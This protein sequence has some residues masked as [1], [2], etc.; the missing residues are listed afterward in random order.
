MS[1][2][3]QRM[4]RDDLL[5]SNDPSAGVIPRAVRYVEREDE[6]GT[7]AVCGVLW[8]V[9]WCVLCV[10]LTYTT[11][12]SLSF[13]LRYLFHAAAQAAQ[14]AAEGV[15]GAVKYTVK[16]SY[17]EIYNE[18]V[19]DLLNLQSQCLQVRWNLTNGFFVKDLI[20]VECSNA[21]DLL[22]TFALAK[23]SH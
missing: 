10:L 3:E 21:E 13:F 7:H 2:V 8:C 23:L 18:Q 9:L 11:H 15:E 19:F 16:A 1:G 17:C 4:E 5:T 14:Q 20:V 6:R 12:P 22:G